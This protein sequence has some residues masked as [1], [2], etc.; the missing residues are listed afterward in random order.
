MIAWFTRRGA[1]FSDAWPSLAAR[2]V[3]RVTIARY[4][5]IDGTADLVMTDNAAQDRYWGLFLVRTTVTY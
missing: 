3:R 2:Y 4:A 5:V 1:T